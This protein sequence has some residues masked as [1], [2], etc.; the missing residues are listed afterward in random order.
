MPKYSKYPRLRPKTY[1]GKSGQVWTYYVYDMRSTG[2]PDIRLGT[3][4]SK[5][6]S[7]W[8]KLNNGERLVSGTLKEAF[9]LWRVEELPKY[10]SKETRTGYAKNLRRIDPV[11]GQMTWEEITLPLLK[12]YL[13]LRKAKVQGNREMS[14]LQ[15][16]WSYAKEEGLTQMHW[17]A[18]GVKGW[19]NEES[20]REIEVTDELFDAV[21]SEADAI[22]KDCMDVASATGMRLKN[23]VALT[24]PNDGMLK[25][26][27]IKTGKLGYFE[28][29]QSSVLSTLVQRREGMKTHSVML[30]T[31][32]TGRAVSLGMLR[33]RYDNARKKAAEKAEKSNNKE[34]AAEI[35][36]MFLRD[37]R[38]RA[39][40]L[41]VDDDE[42]SKLLQHSSVAITK[43]HYRKKATKLK[44]VR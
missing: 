38:S 15:L 26:R 17:P 25:F 9:D 42:A 27:S 6:I 29:A 44:A 35:R 1:K 32:P 12:K 24:M 40:D 33:H 31:T 13:R 34:L 30:I 16:I 18:A 3:D 39:A 36:G 23:V 8:K 20:P 10:E 28:V 14:L 21:Y 41:A 22:L 37:M 2:K 43:K 19:K 11:F 7:L 4:Y 5:A